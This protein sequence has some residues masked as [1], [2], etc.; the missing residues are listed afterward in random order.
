VP[1]TDATYWSDTLGEARESAELVVVNHSL[2]Q[3][4]APH[5]ELDPW[6]GLPG[7]PDSDAGGW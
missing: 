7:S 5:R 2:A 6:V 4:L 3:I 1:V